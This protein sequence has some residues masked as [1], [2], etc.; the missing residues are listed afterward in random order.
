M[1]RQARAIAL[2]LIF[3]LLFSSFVAI[4][5]LLGNRFARQDEKEASKVI[6]IDTPTIILDAGHGGEDG[7]A[8]GANGIYEKDINLRIT[9][10]LCDMLRAAGY[11]VVMTRT[12][13]VLLYDRNEN[14]E[15]RKKV[16]DLA[17]RLAVTQ[18]YENAIFVSIHMNAFPESQYCGLQ[19]YHSPNDP[20]S[21]TLAQEIQTL[22]RDTLMPNNHRKIKPSDGNIYLLDRCTLPA[23]LIECGFLSNPEEAASLATDSYRRQMAAMLFGAISTYLEKENVPLS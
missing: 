23:V 8:I 22:A 17:A 20:R 11:D 2:F 3:S 19:V 7:G 18:E 15:G 16:L 9:K 12:E 1:P 10:L 13:D 5:V 4:M 21:A 14:F 6:K